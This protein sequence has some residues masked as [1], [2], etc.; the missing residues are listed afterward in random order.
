ML[1]L[2]ARVEPLERVVE[3]CTREIFAGGTIVFPHDTGYCLGCDPYRSQAV[4]RVYTAKARPD[5]KPLT[6]LV[7]TP[8]ELL[9][10]APD[11][12]L[13]ILASKRLLPGP[14]TLIVRRPSFVSSE[15]TA[16]HMTVGLR[17]PD[18][19]LARAILERAGPLAVAS[20][21][22]TAETAADLAIENGPTRYDRE[23]TIVD[24]T[25]RRARL[26]REGAV[27]YEQLAERLGPIERT[28]VKVRSQS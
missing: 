6:L 10:Y 11:N 26:V 3:A 4:D 17:V 28:T 14:V 1:V 25:G 22:R 9:E 2:D 23:S 27:S 18:E 8:S 15:V 19:P 13:A 20:V 16:G 5:H 24:L 7:A 12:P 21:E